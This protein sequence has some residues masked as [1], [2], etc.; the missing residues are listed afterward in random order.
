MVSLGQLISA[1][2]KTS[3]TFLPSLTGHERACANPL[4]TG[5]F[6]SSVTLL[7]FRCGIAQIWHPSRKC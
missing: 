5:G 7:G 6:S 3:V 2:L 4:V 1:R